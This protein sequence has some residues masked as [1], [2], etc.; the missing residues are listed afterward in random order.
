MGE[1]LLGN[2]NSVD[3]GEPNR[4]FNKAALAIGSIENHGAVLPH[5]TDVLMSWHVARG[6]AERVDGLL[7][8]PVIPYGVTLHHVGLY[9][10]ISLRPS[11]LTDVLLDVMHSLTRHGIRR[12]WFVNNHDGNIG[13]MEAAA[14]LIRDEDPEVVVARSVDWWIPANGVMPPN[15]FDS[16]GGTWGGHG[17]EAETSWI[18]HTDPERVRME[19][20]ADLGWPYDGVPAGGSVYWSFDELTPEGAAG[21]SRPAA[22]EKGKALLE[23]I[24]EHSVRFLEELD[25]RDWKYGVMT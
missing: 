1:N 13:P 12:F 14:R 19:H 3:L 6:V 17:G 11:T 8:L 20:A 21:D 22:A 9:G 5:D 24:V 2:M 16:A 23:A 25:A 15:L 18:L 7:V 4:E 10:S